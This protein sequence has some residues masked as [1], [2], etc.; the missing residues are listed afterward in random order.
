[1]D[2]FAFTLLVAE[3]Q[4]KIRVINIVGLALFLLR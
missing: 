3:L 2:F 4:E 1:M